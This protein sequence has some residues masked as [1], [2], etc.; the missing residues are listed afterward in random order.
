MSARDDMVFRPSLGTK[1]G[2]DAV[3]RARTERK[4]AEKL[5]KRGPVAKFLR[6]RIARASMRIAS[7]AAGGARIGAAAR[8]GAPVPGVLGKVGTAGVAALL[9]AGVVTLRLAS[10]QPLEGTGAY[11]NKLILGDLDDEARAKMT[12]RRQFESD[13]DLTRIAGNT[14]VNS[15]LV[16]VAADLQRLNLRDEIAKS[17]IEAA[18]PVDNLLD[19]LILRAQKAFLAAWQG[20]GGDAAVQT[21]RKNYGETIN[22]AQ[23]AG[24]R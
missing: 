9:V 3:A 24:A 23:R 18:F 8:G 22:R 6:A 7:A 12:T 13:A 5:G 14:G 2:T 19:M 16:S 10:G 4:L 17:A 1:H 15:Q 21:F 20:A 11:L